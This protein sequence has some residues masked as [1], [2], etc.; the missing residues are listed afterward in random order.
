M[1][2]WLVIMMSALLITALS[3]IYLSGRVSLFD[4]I[5]ANDLPKWRRLL[6][7][8]LLVLLIFVILAK[9]LNLVNAIVCTFYLTFIW[10]ICDLAFAIAKKYFAIEYN[11]YCVGYTA[12][13]LTVVA[14]SIGWYL[15]HNVWQTN[16]TFY[17]DKIKQPLKIAMFADSHIGTT[18]KADG[19]AKHMT[20]IQ[21]QN[22]DLLIIAGDFVDDDTKKE[23][24]IAACKRL[25]KMKTKYGVY[26]VFGN[27]DE[28]YYGREYRGY[29]GLDLV[30][31]L[32]KNNVVVL[33]DETR[34][35]DENF[36]LI[37]RKDA[38]ADKEHR[39]GRLKMAD[40]VRPL[41]KDKYL[42]VID[43][44]PNDYVSQVEAKVDL[45]LSGHTHGGQL[46]PLNLVGKWIGAN[47]RIYGHEKRN[48]TDF[49]VTS[50]ISDWTIKFKTG[51]KSEF[52]MINIEPK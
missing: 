10:I 47:D 1:R 9:T 31:E 16:Y 50:G 43:H 30:N 52:V 7:G 17:S 36:Y 51:T 13:I 37:G 40:I 22:P 26:F 24:M 39:G 46:F 28:G 49:L 33:E 41:N 35:I 45:V 23:D 18:F 48:Q 4:F 8:F 21:E 29:S 32:R 6:R 3:L 5:R 34:L 12:I 38:S 11:G 2:M 44:Q 20:T 14:L 42:I 27:H 19:F 15:N 25:G